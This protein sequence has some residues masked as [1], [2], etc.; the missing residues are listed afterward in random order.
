MKKIFLPLLLLSTSLLTHAQ[1][2]FEHV[3][4][5]NH[6]VVD[7]EAC[8][9]S[10]ELPNGEYITMGWNPGCQFCQKP[11]YIRRYDH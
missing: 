7:R 2:T 10:L 4:I 6:N 3:F 1:N 5:A 11:Y 8:V 9:K